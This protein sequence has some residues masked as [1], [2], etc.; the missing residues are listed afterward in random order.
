MKIT[1]VIV[2][3]TGRLRGVARRKEPLGLV[4]CMLVLG[5]SANAQDYNATIIT[6]DPPDSVYTYSEAINPAGA[7]AGYS[8]DANIVAHGF[9]RAPDGTFTRRSGRR[10]RCRP[11][12][13]NG[14]D[15]PA[16]AIPG[17]YI[18]A[19]G[20]NHGYVRAA[21][22]AITMFDVLGAGAASGQGTLPESIN[23]AGDIAGFYI[24]EGNVKRGFLSYKHGAT[25]TFEAPGAGTGSGQ[26]TYAACNNPAD[27]V[28]GWYIDATGV[29]RGFLRFP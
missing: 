9:L 23:P 16:G 19:S 3:L 20:V 8:F 27:A 5:L 10:H 12:H 17:E 26:G 25:T 29:Q 11:R 1:K 13:C 22:G 21:G 4:F 24:D 7:I 18:D 28:T 14:G 2:S 15:H 6:F